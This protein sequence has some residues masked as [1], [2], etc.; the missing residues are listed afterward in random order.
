MAIATHKG[1]ISFGLVHIPVAM[2]KATQ[3][4]RI[5]FNQLHVN[6]GARIKQKKFCPVRLVW[7]GVILQK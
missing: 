5:G 4:E 1:A 3:E 7:Q 6:C 2:Y